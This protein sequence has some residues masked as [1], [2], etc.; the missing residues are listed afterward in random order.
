MQAY[1]ESRVEDL[2]SFLPIRIQLFPMNSD[3][4]PDLEALKITQKNIF[5]HL[6]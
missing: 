1:V 6:K 5:K 3:P 4:Y 2:N